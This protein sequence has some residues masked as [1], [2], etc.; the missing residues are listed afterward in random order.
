MR[1]SAEGRWKLEDGK[2]RSEFVANFLPPSLILFQSSAPAVA[3]PAGDSP[4][5]L[6]VLGSVLFW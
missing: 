4:T 5:S 2:R 6:T 1:P 3:D